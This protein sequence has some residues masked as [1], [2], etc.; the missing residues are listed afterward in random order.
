MPRIRTIVPDF[1]EDERFVKVSLQATLLYIGMKN[2]ADDAGVI[3]SNE[4]LIRNKV[5]PAREDIRKQEI[6]RWLKELIDN[7]ILVPFEH[8]EKGYYVMDL[9]SERIDKPQ[10]SKIPQEVIDRAKCEWQYIAESGD[11]TDILVQEPESVKEDDELTVED[12]TPPPSKREPP[13]KKPEIVTQDDLDFKKFQ[14]WVLE[15]APMVAKMSEPFTKKEYLE[16]RKDFPPKVV[17]ELLISMHNWKPLLQKNRSANKT[18]RNWVKKDFNKDGN[19]SDSKTGS[20][21]IAG[22]R[23]RKTD[24]SPDYAASILQRMGVTGG[25]ETVQQPPNS[26]RLP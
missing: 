8:E 25:L 16:L 14:E 10:K 4:V 20:A 5:F 23:Q 19:N 7:S 11:V 17:S 24:V 15:H 21:G 18:F 22:V 3:L 26:D 1:W 9:S 12:S 13:Q 6:S 2:F